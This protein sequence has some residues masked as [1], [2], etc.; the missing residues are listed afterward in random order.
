MIMMDIEMP[1]NCTE[2]PF[3][4]ESPFDG[5]SCCYNFAAKCF[6]EAVPTDK[7]HEDCPFLLTNDDQPLRNRSAIWYYETNIKP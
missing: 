1:E 6:N 2:C 4:V 3:V 7:R 5:E